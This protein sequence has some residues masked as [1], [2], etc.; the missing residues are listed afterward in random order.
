MSIKLERLNRELFIIENSWQR[1]NR[2]HSR[3]EIENMLIRQYEIE[4]ETWSIEDV[5]L[6]EY[7]YDQLDNAY[8]VTSK[9]AS[10]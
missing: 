4:L 6:R 7:I 2:N 3:K 10:T 8:S 5:F 1:V 9:R